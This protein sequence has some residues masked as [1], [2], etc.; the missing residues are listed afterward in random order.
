MRAEADA[1]PVARCRSVREMV[2]HEPEEVCIRLDLQP[3]RTLRLRWGDDLARLRLVRT[4]NPF[5][6]AL[7][8]DTLDILDAFA[9]RHHKIVSDAN[10]ARR[11]PLV[12]ALRQRSVK[13]RRAARA[14]EHVQVV[15]FG[16]AQLRIALMHLER[17]HVP[18]IPERHCFENLAVAPSMRL[19]L[20][21]DRHVLDGH[22]R[23]FDIDERP[24]GVA[25]AHDGVG[26]HDDL[27]AVEE[28]LPRLLV[29]VDVHVVVVAVASKADALLARRVEYAR[30][31]ELR[32]RLPERRRVLEL[33]ACRCRL[34]NEH[35]KMGR[36]VRLHLTGG[37][38]D[39][40][41]LAF[42]FH[43]LRILS[44]CSCCRRLVCTASRCTRPRCSSAW[45]STAPTTARSF[46]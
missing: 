35:A 16:A 27:N 8:D 28:V 5:D 15:V 7:R 12:L 17:I 9:D 41:L 4:L 1:R 22:E 25:R 23:P 45:R 21:S 32:P 29:V 40:R 18:V 2:S 3:H 31:G 26:L 46:R 19:Y 42:R 43:G 14:S 39:Y 6:I 13:V 20:V 38:V 34:L 37:E 24:G 44:P 36:V 10:L 33:R 30:Y 11:N